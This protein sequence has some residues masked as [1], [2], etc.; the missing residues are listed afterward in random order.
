[1]QGVQPLLDCVNQYLPNPGEVTNYALRVGSEEKV[2][3]VFCNRLFFKFL[4]LKARNNHPNL[5]TVIPPVIIFILVIPL[6]TQVPMNPERSADKPGVGLAFKLE[7]SQYGQL[8]YVRMYQGC[9]KRGNNM[10]N[11][12]TG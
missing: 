3:A 10:I 2:G 12:R 6:L 11:T 4:N 7:E 9:F 1:M 5:F 8:T